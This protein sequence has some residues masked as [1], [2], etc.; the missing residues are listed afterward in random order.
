MLKVLNLPVRSFGP[1]AFSLTVILANFVTE[2]IVFAIYE[3]KNVLFFSPQ[4]ESPD[5]EEDHDSTQGG[6]YS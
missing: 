5:L 4:S 6:F 1:G 3:T 2:Q